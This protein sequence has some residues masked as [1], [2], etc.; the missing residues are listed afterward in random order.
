MLYWV[1]D[2]S[3]FEKIASTSTS[4]EIWDILEK[5]FKGVDWVK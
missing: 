4:K 3:I 2:K 5:M 1:V